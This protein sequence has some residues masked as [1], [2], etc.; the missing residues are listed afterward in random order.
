MVIL[1]KS[2]EKAIIYASKLIDRCKK[3][4][5]IKS[6]LKLE[7]DY[8]IKDA[9]GLYYTDKPNRILV[10]P[11]MCESI[12]DYT[13]PGY[14]N[15]FSTFGVVLHEFSHYLSLFV[16]KG[17]VEAY[18]QCF[19]KALF[20][21][22]SY[23]LSEFDKDEEVAEMITLYLSNPYLLKLISN[24]RYEFIKCWFKSPT[25]CNKEKCYRIWKKFNR[26]LKTK[27]RK[28][29]MISFDRKGNLKLWQKK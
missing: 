11:A 24:D 18:T 13:S 6:E 25:V 3:I 5:N 15:D 21:I 12:G 14:C 17:M 2:P 9:L 1:L 16:Y 23:P 7:I 19:G 22:S 28:K 27:L 10:N 20:R 29:F 4:N 8:S 26:R